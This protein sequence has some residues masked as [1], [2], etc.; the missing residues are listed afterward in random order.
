MQ[1][2]DIKSY[3][4]TPSPKVKRSKSLSIAMGRDLGRGYYSTGNVY[5]SASGKM[6]LKAARL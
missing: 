2:I 3:P 5:A 4:S 1:L 6:L